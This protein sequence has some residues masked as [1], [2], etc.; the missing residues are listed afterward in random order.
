[1]GAITQAMAK[2]C[3]E[4]GVEIRTDAP[5]R[6]VILDKGKARGAVL[7]DGTAIR[8]RA[9][10]SN[11]NPRLLYGGLIADEAAARRIRG[12]HPEL[13]MR[14]R[15]VPHERG[16]FASLPNFTAAPAPARWIITAAAS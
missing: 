1:M 3:A 11:I 13:E 12:A 9:V 7:E 14:L 4:A 10:V 2:A 6:E 15:H 8:G 5:V 16:A